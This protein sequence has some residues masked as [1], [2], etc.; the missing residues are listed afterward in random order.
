ELKETSMLSTKP[1]RSVTQA[2]KD[3]FYQDGVVL[4][5]G[6]LDTDWIK[7]LGVPL[8]RALAQGEA[9]NLGVMAPS[10][11]P[12]PSE[13]AQSAGA[14]GAAVAGAPAFS[15][16]TDHW[17]HD[18]TF[19]GFATASPLPEIASQLLS[20]ER[21]WLW[22][23]SVLVKE[24]G[25]PF[26]TKFHTDAGYFHVDGEQ[27]CTMWIPL[28]AASPESGAVSWVRGSHLEQVVYRPN[29]F[30]TDEPIP[31]TEGEIVPDVLGTPELAARVISFDLEPGDLTVHH[32]RTL[33]GSPGNS[34]QTRRRAVS[35]RYCG[36]DARYRRKPGLPER[37]GM[38]D[39]AAGDMLGPP[40][41]PLVWPR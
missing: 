27:I 33:H 17:K 30:V 11:N 22:E 14:A 41:C 5:R 31:G 7:A 21:I 2:E 18:E 9:V 25:S 23:D 4:L 3:S 10:S 26:A 39:A 20:S 40:S 13:S 38:E 15:A 19:H 12:E 28:D 32:A 36:D 16:G 34:S 8:E 37:A 24:A 1:I 6:I 29:M 35:L